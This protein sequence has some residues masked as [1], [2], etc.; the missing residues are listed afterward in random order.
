MERFWSKVSVLSD[1]ECWEW[2]RQRNA[3]GYGVFWANGKNVPAHNFALSLSC[4]R[5]EG[6]RSAIHSCDNPP[7]CNPA[8]LR[9]G[10]HQDNSDDKVSRNRQPKGEAHSRSILTDEDADKILKMRVDGYTVEEICQNLNLS[11]ASAT[12][13]YC[14]LTWKHRHGVDGNPTLEEL[15]KCKR[16][17]K[18]VKKKNTVITDSMADFIMQSRVK[19]FGPTYI[20]KALNVPRGNVTQAYSGVAFV[21]RLGK[22][23]NPTLE[24]LRS[25]KNR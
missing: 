4:E 15:K 22:Y 14:G 1:D 11:K 24:E 9:W 23:G 5:I 21:E 17:P 7:C 10:D 25:A 13:V 6:K 19:G 20:A 18:K 8:H 16:K 2:T 12:K 3:K